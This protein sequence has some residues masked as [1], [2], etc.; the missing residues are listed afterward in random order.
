VIWG[1]AIVFIMSVFHNSN[2]YLPVR[3][4]D[5]GIVD[6]ISADSR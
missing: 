4:V 2:Y 5:W 6:P 1:A 3:L